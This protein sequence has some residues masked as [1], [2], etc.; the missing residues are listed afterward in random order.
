M[1]SNI[2]KLSFDENMR[3]QAYHKAEEYFGIQSYLKTKSEINENALLLID[4]EWIVQKLLRSRFRVYGTIEL[5]D[6]KLGVLSEPHI[7]Y[8]DNF[9]L[10]GWAVCEITFK[11]L[12]ISSQP[13]LKTIFQ[14]NKNQKHLT[15]IE[16]SEPTELQF[17]NDDVTYMLQQL[18][19]A[20]NPREYFSHKL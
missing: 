4:G 5:R 7:S 14:T 20:N 12:L 18:R 6:N 1:R 9:R 3:L 11:V 13:Y 17:Q 8:A 10:S 2:N 19:L 15:K 16:L